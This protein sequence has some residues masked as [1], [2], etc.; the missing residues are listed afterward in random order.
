MPHE[1]ML[2][3]RKTALA[4]VLSDYHKALELLQHAAHTNHINGLGLDLPSQK[5]ITEMITTIVKTYQ[6]PAGSQRV[7]N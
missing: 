4:S 7:E 3:E 1:H 2:H 5:P 6:Q